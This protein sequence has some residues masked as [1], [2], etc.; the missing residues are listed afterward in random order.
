MSTVVGLDFGDKNAVIAAAGRGGVDVLLNGGSNRLNV[1]TGFKSHPVENSVFTE[2]ER[3]ESAE[4][5]VEVDIKHGHIHI[6]MP[7]RE[8]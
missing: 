4:R 5:N 1:S 6:Y 2:R 7:C 8:P 3:K